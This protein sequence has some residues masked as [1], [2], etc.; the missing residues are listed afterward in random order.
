MPAPALSPSRHHTRLLR[1]PEVLALTAMSRSEV[2]RRIAAKSFPTPIKL[3]PRLSAWSEE[4]VHAWIAAQ[5]GGPDP[6][7]VHS[8]GRQ[9]GR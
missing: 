1:L 7:D 4:A 2:Y 6:T 5:L 8:G 9:W 3:G